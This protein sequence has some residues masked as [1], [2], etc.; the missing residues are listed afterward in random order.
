MN[1]HC[2]SNP[3][4][5]CDFDGTIA[6]I[7]TAQKALELFADPSWRKIEEEYEKGVLSFENSLRKEYALIAASSEI[8][9]KE[10][11]PLTVVRPYFGRLVQYCESNHV[12]LVVVSG[13][14]DFI[15]QHFLTQANWSNSI[16]IHAPK[17]KRGVNGFDVTFPERLGSSS[18]NFKDDLVLF[19]KS[20]GERVFFV[21]DGVSDFPAAKESQYA[22]AIRDSKLAKLCKSA[23][24]PCKEID[25][26]QQ[27]VNELTDS[28]SEAVHP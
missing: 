25:D 13:G 5:L 27:I 22:F 14:L 9:L 18:I 28:S 4:V 19:H 11:D 10:L 6:N 8:I 17:T 20:R 12:P 26:F 3:I 16:S 2:L 24:I 15:I 1:P 21:G 7:D 23:S